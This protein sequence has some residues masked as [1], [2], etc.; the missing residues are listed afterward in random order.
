LKWLYRLGKGEAIAT[1]HPFTSLREQKGRKGGGS[2]R[3]GE[4]NLKNT[5]HVE[6]QLPAPETNG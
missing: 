5:V 1:S 2:Q 4:Q 6:K 3:A